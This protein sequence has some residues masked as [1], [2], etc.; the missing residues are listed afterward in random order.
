MG[1]VYTENAYILSTKY[2][3]GHCDQDDIMVYESWFGEFLNLGAFTP[4]FSTKDMPET[5]LNLIYAIII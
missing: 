4:N 3:L 1:V 2:E 5:N